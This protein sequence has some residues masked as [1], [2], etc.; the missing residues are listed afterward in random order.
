[1]RSFTIGSIGIVA[2][3]VTLCLVFDKL[4]RPGWSGLWKMVAS[5]GFLIVAWRAGATL[6]AYGVAILIGLL[7]SWWGDLFLIFARR[8]I[9]LAG[10][11]CFLLAHMAYVAA[12]AA[13][14][15]A[16]QWSVAAIL[17]LVLPVVAIQFWLGPHLT[18]DM[19]IPVYAYMAVIS[20]MLVLAIG[21]FGAGGPWLIPL[22]ALAFYISDIFVARERFV[23]PGYSNRLFG[24]PLYFLG[25]V[26]LSLSPAWV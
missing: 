7:F 13:H 18:G 5:C 14:G 21:A 8:S 6:T 22:G 10:L 26:L 11:V 19:R 20:T 23:T 3:A 16:W 9:F 17:A 4:K 12:F 24:L 25:Q 15:I 2:I 1:M